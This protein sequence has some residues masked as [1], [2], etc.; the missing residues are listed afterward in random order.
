MKNSPT[1]HNKIHTIASLQK[2]M[3][4][5]KLLGKKIAFTNGCFDVLHVGHMASISDAAK[6]ADC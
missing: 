6:E 4:I 3:N 2:Q 5:W 1:V